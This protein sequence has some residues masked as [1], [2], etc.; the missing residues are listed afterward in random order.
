MKNVIIYHSPHCPD[1]IMAAAIAF[2]A[3]KA[4]GEE[5]EL[6]PASYER[7]LE[8]F[9]LAERV[10]GAMVYILDFSFS[11]EDTDRLLAMVGPHGK[12]VVCDHHKTA[13]EKFA[14]TCGVST[15]TSRTTW[16]CSTR[17][18]RRSCVRGSRHS[19]RQ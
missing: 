9:V 4:R 13:V 11:P 17:G 15:G 2:R 14:R 1:G 19:P 18:L 8:E 10:S 5:A 3:L 16:S 12:V 6:V 7:P